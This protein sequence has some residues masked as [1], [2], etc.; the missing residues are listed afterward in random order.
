MNEIKLD[1]ETHVYTKGNIIIPGV[2]TIL[3]DVGIIEYSKFCTTGRGS[4]MH[5]VMELYFRGVLDYSQINQEEIDMIEW[6]ASALKEQDLSV[7][8]TE[9]LLYNE[10]YHYCGTCDLVLENDDNE[11]IIADLKT[12]HKREEWHKIQLAAYIH[13]MKDVAHGMI[14]YE[15]SRKYKMVSYNESRPYFSLFKAALT[16]YNFK[17]GNI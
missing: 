6:I 2:T 15:R 8:E 4:R 14:L 3:S 16:V 13:S 9:K 10:V 1:K 5:R 11:I 12:G 17:H 7:V